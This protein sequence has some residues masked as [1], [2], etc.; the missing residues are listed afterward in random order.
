MTVRQTPKDDDE[1]RMTPLDFV[2]ALNVAP[3]DLDRGDEVFNIYRAEQ[4]EGQSVQGFLS[5]VNVI[6]TFLKL[7]GSR[8]VT[9]WWFRFFA[10]LG[11]H[12]RGFLARSRGKFQRF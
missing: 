2:R 1:S 8:G 9:L 7:M 10:D 6:Q 12:V 4:T 3:Q 5:Y 11:R